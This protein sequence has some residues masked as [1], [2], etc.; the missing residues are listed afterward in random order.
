MVLSHTHR[1]EFSVLSSLSTP[2]ALLDVERIELQM[3]QPRKAEAE[4]DIVLAA[5]Y[6]LWGS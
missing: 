1:N 6:C 5:P 2:F 3:P 4:F